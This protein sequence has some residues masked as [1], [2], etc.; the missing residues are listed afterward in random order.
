MKIAFFS[1]F[2]NHH[3]LPLCEAFC[4]TE[5][6][7]FKFVACEK[8]PEDRIK[9]GYEDMNTKY[10]FVLRAYEDSAAAEKIALEYDVVIFGSC[11]TSYIAL[12]MEENKLSFRFCERSLKKGTWRR[13]IP[14]TRKKIYEGYTKYK[15]KN[16]YILGASSYAASDLALCGFDKKK[17]FEWGYFPAVYEKDLEAVF[18]EK[19]ENKVPEILYAG[20]LLHWKHVLDA[21]KAVHNLKKQN[22][23]AHL[24]IV[25]EGECAGKIASYVSQNALSDC[26]TMFSFMSP[27]EVRAYMDKS[28]IYVLSSSFYEGWGA[29]VNES[30]NSACAMVVSHAVGSAAYLINSGKNGYIYKFADVRELTEKLKALVND[31]ALRESFGREA[32]KTVTDLWTAEVAAE[33]FIK[34]C[35]TL[36]SGK[37]PSSIYDNG[38]C[39]AVK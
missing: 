39:S 28:D 6:M 24:T 14:R 38:P 16:L 23:P 18:G 30:M 15:K 1:N 9:M 33:R 12:R 32:Y 7:E 5:G 20:R 2:L 17:C 37:D 35:K 10:P 29:V 21:V 11:P 26:V 36:E 4:R 19:R 8:I 13:F 31:R 27:I 3:Q 22:I 34:I 25:G